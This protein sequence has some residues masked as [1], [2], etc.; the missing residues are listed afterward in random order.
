MGQHTEFCSHSPWALVE[1]GWGRLESCEE[2]LGFVALGRELRGKLLRS[3]V[4]SYST[5]PQM[6]SFLGGSCPFVQPQPG[7]K[8]LPD[9]LV[10]LSTHL[11][12]LL[13]C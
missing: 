7:G 4:L 2:R 13:P 3:P 5:E 8:Q 9:L 10:F 1:G 12:E 6:P 11:A